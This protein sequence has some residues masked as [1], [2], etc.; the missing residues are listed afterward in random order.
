MGLKEKVLI[1][2][3]TRLNEAIIEGKYD[4][5][6]SWLIAYERNLINFVMNFSKEK[7]GRIIEEQIEE[8]GRIIQAVNKNRDGQSI[9][10]I[11]SLMN[12]QRSKVPFS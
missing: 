6:E 5:A 12:Y 8:L 11:K 9:H 7:A 3:S 1:Q 2:S 10:R 4:E